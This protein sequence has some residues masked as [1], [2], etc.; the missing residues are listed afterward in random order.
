M[1]IRI[2]DKQTAVDRPRVAFNCVE[3]IYKIT[4]SST[5]LM[6]RE[7]NREKFRVRIVIVPPEIPEFAK[8]VIACV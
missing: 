1:S 4:C 8:F 3:T 2:D 6:L 7:S 5:S